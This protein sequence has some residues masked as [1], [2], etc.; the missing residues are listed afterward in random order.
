MT[1]AKKR[2]GPLVAIGGA[3]ALIAPAVRRVTHRSPPE[4]DRQIR[5]Q[6]P[7]LNRARSVRFAALHRGLNASGARRLIGMSAC[8]RELCSDSGT[9]GC[10]IRLRSLRWCADQ[11][12]YKSQGN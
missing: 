5:S 2:N 6:Y 8:T 10:G 3:G 4:R 9:A 7:I 1:L 12:G 11:N